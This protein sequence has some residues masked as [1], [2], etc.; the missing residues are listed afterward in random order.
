MGADRL[1]RELLGTL[2]AAYADGHAGYARVS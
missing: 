1:T 2:E